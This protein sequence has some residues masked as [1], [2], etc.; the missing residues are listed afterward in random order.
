M[1]ATFR[2]HW[3]SSGSAF[4]SVAPGAVADA[5]FGHFVCK[6]IFFVLV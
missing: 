6:E 2:L 3:F 1:R 4:S 5:E